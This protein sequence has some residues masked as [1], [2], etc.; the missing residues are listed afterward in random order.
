MQQR[1]FH[2]QSPPLR[3]RQTGSM[4]TIRPAYA[5][6]IQSQVQRRYNSDASSLTQDL[7]PEALLQRILQEYRS[8][9]VSQ[10][11][12]S[13][14]AVL[15]F[16]KQC[17]EF[18]QSINSASAER[19]TPAHAAGGN[20][21]SS[22]L[23][24]D[25]TSFRPKQPKKTS[26]QSKA[27]IQVYSMLNNLIRDPKIFI[28]PEVL[29]SYTIMQCELDQADHFPEVFT[30]YAAKP[31]LRPGTAKQDTV[32]SSSTPNVKSAQNAIPAELANMALDV[33]IRH[34]NLSLCLAI[35]DKSFSM[36]AFY[37]AKVIRKAGVPIIGF[38]AAPPAAYAAAS[39]VASLQN[40]MEPSTA[41]WMAFSAIMAYIGFTS[42]IGMIAISTANDD[43]ERVV[44]MPGTPLHQR[45]LREEERAAMDK[46]AVA[47][48]FKDISRRGEEEGEEWES[49][50][51]F[52]G[53]RGM[54]LDKSDLMEGME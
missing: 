32:G 46:V 50:R 47:W 31:V 13:E 39:Y 42:S 48:G 8:I 36:P 7:S 35:I 27:K 2:L 49:L 53:M 28:S 34:K 21:T 9:I 15:Q 10:Q 3:P 16:L 14:E 11:I 19:A 54:V 51:E 26:F 25:S 41:T 18:I 29:R 52:I 24:L 17:E 38:A 40:T 44:W 22:L 4:K 1:S 45:W 5:F 20:A 37:R 23:D 30:L 12:P 6:A 43:M 33:A